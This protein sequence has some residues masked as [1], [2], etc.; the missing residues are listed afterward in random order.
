MEKEH[1]E[2]K[3]RATKDSED[4]DALKNS[5]GFTG[6][7][8]LRAKIISRQAGPIMITGPRGSGKS[9]IAARIHSLSNN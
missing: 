3:N 2:I 9:T 4:A 7:T 5:I 6:E 8:Q 1:N